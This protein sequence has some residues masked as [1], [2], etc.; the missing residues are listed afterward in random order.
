M[1]AGLQKVVH[2]LFRLVTPPDTVL[3]AVLLRG[4]TESREHLLQWWLCA[5]LAVIIQRHAHNYERM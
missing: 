1:A 2:H 3:D 5:I 4:F